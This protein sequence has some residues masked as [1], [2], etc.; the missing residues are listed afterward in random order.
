[1]YADMYICMLGKCELFGDIVIN[2]FECTP[3]K[4]HMYIVVNIQVQSILNANF[5]WHGC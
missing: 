4:P 2:Y 3:T 1:M 5:A